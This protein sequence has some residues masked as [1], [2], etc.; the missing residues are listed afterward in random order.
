L[1]D[2]KLQN[3][4]A[5]GG[6]ISR[7]LSRPGRE[8]SDKDGLKMG[9]ENGKLFFAEPL[10]S[11]SMF[12]LA[13]PGKGSFSEEKIHILYYFFLDIQYCVAIL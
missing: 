3:H 11:D 8:G 12:A 2:P 10:S 9:C 13:C 1:F 5:N 7:I 4:P 6:T